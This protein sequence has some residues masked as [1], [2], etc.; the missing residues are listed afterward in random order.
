MKK[1]TWFF[2]FNFILGSIG[3]IT[4]LAPYLLPSEQPHA[5]LRTII[6]DEIELSYEGITNNLL[7]EGNIKN[8]GDAPALINDFTI[9]IHD[10]GMENA[11]P[12]FPP[13]IDVSKKYVDIGESISLRITAHFGLIPLP[14][15][16]NY[17]M[18][19]TIVYNDGDPQEYDELIVR[20]S[21]DQSG[22]IIK[23]TGGL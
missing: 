13:Y 19:F 15:N 12:I 17:N 2:V 18:H 7:M 11:T 23:A 20:L 8:L 21:V 5:N 14:E 6:G 22:K 9:Y 16:E 10:L 1:E 4:G 3:T